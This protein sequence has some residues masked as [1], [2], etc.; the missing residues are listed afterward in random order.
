M[1]GGPTEE[2][3]SASVKEK[4]ENHQKQPTH[5]RFDRREA[6]RTSKRGRQGEGLTRKVEKGSVLDYE[7]L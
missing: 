3:K 7:I 6:K 1:V 2:G 5:H 4:S